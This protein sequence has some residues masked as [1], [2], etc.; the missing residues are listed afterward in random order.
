[1]W[2][3]DPIPVMSRTKTIASWSSVSPRLT[4]NDPTGTQVNR[5]WLTERSVESRPRRATNSISPM[6]NDPSTGAQ[7]RRWPKRSVRRPPSSRIAAPRSGRPM[8]NHV[9]E[10]PP[11]AWTV[12]SAP[13]ARRYWCTEVP[14]GSVL[15][16]VGVV[17]RGRTASAENGDD[18]R[19]AHHDLCCG[20]N[21][22]EEREDLTVE[23]AVHPRERHEREVAGV[24]HQLDAHE[25][26]DR[27]ATH[28]HTRR[29]D[30]EQQ[31]RHDDVGVGAHELSPR[32]TSSTGTRT[33]SSAAGGASSTRDGGTGVRPGR[34]GRMVGTDS[35]EGEPSGS[36]AGVSTALWRA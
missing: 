23:V 26:N 8:S 7:P 6:A 29:A 32:S 30:G 19:Q 18:D 20:D 16:E 1:M 24:E 34:A 21:H 2:I 3:R 33:S 4:W 35:D 17:D 13:S 31:G 11:V 10:N 14:I 22:G 36:R 27:V 25:H 9:R 12:C 28:E 15:E 5:C